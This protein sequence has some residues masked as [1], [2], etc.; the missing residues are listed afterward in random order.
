[1]SVTPLTPGPGPD[2]FTCQEIVEAVT[3]YLE[4]ALTPAQV[5]RFER[6]LRMCPPCHDYVAQIRRTIRLAGSLSADQL[7][8]AERERLVR[9]FRGWKER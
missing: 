2:D 6:H 3:D 9:L 1:M 8:P 7:D 4:G 5:A